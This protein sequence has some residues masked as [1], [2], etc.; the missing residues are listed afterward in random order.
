ME[1]ILP[2]IRIIIIIGDVFVV[3][4]SELVYKTIR[5]FRQLRKI[6]IGD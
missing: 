5:E 6:E 4:I 2:E 1:G 3:G